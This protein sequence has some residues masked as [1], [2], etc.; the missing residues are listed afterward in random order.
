MQIH[1]NSINNI[2][3]L[4]Y[5]FP[6]NFPIYNWGNTLYSPPVKETYMHYHNCLEIGFCYKGSGVFLVDNQILP[7]SKGDVSIIFSEQIHIANSNLYD[8]SSWHFVMIDT[9]NLLSIFQNE[10]IS[11]FT[12]LGNTPIDFPYILNSQSHPE[13]WQL[14][15][16]IINQLI[17]KKVNYQTSVLGLSLA[18]ISSLEVLSLSFDKPKCNQ[19]IHEDYHLLAPALSFISNNLTKS[20]TLEQLSKKCNM[21]ESSFRRYFKK[22]IG[23]S[24]MDFIYTSRI[25]IASQLLYNKKFSISQVSFEVGYNSLSSFNR[26]FKKYM[27][28][29]PS[30]WRKNS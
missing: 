29:S 6:S 18:L 30:D 25:K 20:I 23:V 7:F 10:Y 12:S 4:P 21:S 14:V 3:Y 2:E 5:S 27:G 8:P 1:S 16:M 13:V 26:H 24:P 19:A 9:K 28:V 15:Q 22:V 17:C 11:Q